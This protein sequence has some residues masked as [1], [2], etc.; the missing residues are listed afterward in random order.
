MC[1][2]FSAGAPLRRRRRLPRLHARTRRRGAVQGASGA[3]PISSQRGALWL[4]RTCAQRQAAAGWRLFTWLAICVLTCVAAGTQPLT[5]ILTVHEG[6]DDSLG[7]HSTGLT[8]CEF[9][10]TTPAKVPPTPDHRPSPRTWPAP[11][12]CVRPACV[13]CTAMHPPR[14]ERGLAGNARSAR[15]PQP[16]RASTAAASRCSCFAPSPRR[17]ATCGSSS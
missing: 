5:D 9:Q 6:F 8:A 17:S 3:P 1:G 16:S 10:M 11:G 14:R 4:H 12:V 7:R 2:R 15:G 13:L